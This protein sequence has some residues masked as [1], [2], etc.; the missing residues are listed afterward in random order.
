MVNCNFKGLTKKVSPSCSG[1]SGYISDIESVI[2]AV[3]QNESTGPVFCKAKPVIVASNLLRTIR[4]RTLATLYGFIHT[5]GDSGKRLASIRFIIFLYKEL[6]LKLISL[7]YQLE[8]KCLVGYLII[9]FYKH[10]AFYRGL[11]VAATSPA[12]AV[13][14]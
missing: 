2:V 8:L 10:T 9:F 4:R 7:V 6:F 3:H 14:V 1:Y 5:I 13:N 12:S 11:G